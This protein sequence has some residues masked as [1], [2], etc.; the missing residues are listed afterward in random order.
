M[1][2][3]PVTKVP[4]DSVDRIVEGMTPDHQLWV[5]HYAES[6]KDHDLEQIQHYAEAIRVSET[7]DEAS[8]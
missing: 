1:A 7:A 5:R 3:K 2:R 6:V 4:K 8:R